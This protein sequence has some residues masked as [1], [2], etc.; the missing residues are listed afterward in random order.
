MIL[1]WTHCV[2]D[3]NATIT[4]EG[5]REECLAVYDHIEQAG[6]DALPEVG[7]IPRPE[8]YQELKPC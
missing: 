4:A 3:I 5:T 7:V 8:F 6:E 2:G 1:Q